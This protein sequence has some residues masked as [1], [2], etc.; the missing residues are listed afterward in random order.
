[1]KTIK[2]L[3]LAAGLSVGVLVSSC[4]E[5]ES[6][7]PNITLDVES[8]LFS[9][10]AD[11]AT[12]VLT[13]NVNWVAETDEDWAWV[14]P[15]NGSGSDEPQAFKVFVLALAEGEEERTC[16][17]SVIAG[18]GTYAIE[19]RQ[20]SGAELSVNLTSLDF[21]DTKTSEEKKFRVTATKQ[22]TAANTGTSD[23]I[24]V[25]P[26]NAAAGA[27]TISATVGLNTEEGPREGKIVLRS[28]VAP[29]DTLYKTIKVTQKKTS[30]PFFDVDAFDP[31][32]SSYLATTS[33][34]LSDKGKP[35]K[36][37]VTSSSA[38]TAS[39]AENWLTLTPASGGAG[40]C[41]V[42]VSAT[43]Q[44]ADAE[45]TAKF[46]ITAGANNKEISV[47]QGKAGNYWNDNEVYLLREHTVGNGVAMV[48][49][50]DGFDR[51][52]LKKGGWYETQA[53][54]L[55]EEWVLNCAIFKDHKEYFDVYIYMAESN[56]RGVFKEMDNRYGSGKPDIRFGDAVADINK[57]ATIGKDCPGEVAFIFMGNGMIG[58]YAY[59]EIRAGIYSTAEGFS[60]GWSA[61]EFVGHAFS[62]L[63]DEYVNAGYM[64][65]VPEL[66]RYQDKGN[67]ICLDCSWTTDT[68]LY[69]TSSGGTTTNIAESNGNPVVAWKPF[70]GRPGYEEVCF[71]EGGFYEPTGIW[72]PEANSVMIDHVGNWNY[73]N[74]IS[75]WIIYKKIH[76]LA[77][78]SDTFNF[79]KFLEYDAD[80]SLNSETFNNSKAYR[81]M[82]DKAI[83]TGC[84]YCGS[85]WQNDFTLANPC[86]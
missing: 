15:S 31:Q 21:N 2:F 55:M 11:S 44:T 27:R 37:R 7:T 4:E 51:E 26:K 72:R 63:A 23:W 29:G 14:E 66:K 61:H 48:V 71:Y 34:S 43:E 30:T 77:G 58:G 42:T 25:S 86:E 5:K 57:S 52:D 54:T 85:K 62:G 18:G 64:G 24:T 46:T 9:S 45:R 60:F 36:I 22:W 49:I 79:E 33:V 80:A 65:G 1:M 78:D 3:M 83:G 10:A 84:A 74:A 12:V 75:R 6:N 47:T 70:L 19:L 17:V 41:M 50:G 16:I 59:F 76:D 20:V 35:R 39:A 32:K 69:W 38:W 53:A 13:S 8:L 68:S 82:R 56:E 67:G 40:T 28:I 73:P 81:D